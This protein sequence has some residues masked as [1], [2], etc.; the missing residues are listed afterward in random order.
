MSS[1]ANRVR[2]S[3]EV[4]SPV[5]VAQDRHTMTSIDFVIGRKALPSMGVT[6][7]TGRTQHVTRK[8]R[9]STGSPV[10]LR[11]RSASELPTPAIASND[12]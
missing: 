9:A 3:A 7:N 10:S 2:R 11:I 1:F 6:R 5:S 8:P 4:L 12:S